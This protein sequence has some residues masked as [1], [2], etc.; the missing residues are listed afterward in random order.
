M[1]TLVGMLAALT[2]AYVSSEPCLLGRPFELTL[3]PVLVNTPQSDRWRELE[4][5]ASE[6]QLEAGVACCLCSPSCSPILLHA[7]PLSPLAR[8]QPN[9]EKWALWLR[10]AHRT[11][12]S[13]RSVRHPSLH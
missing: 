1:A 4:A 2:L 11:R 8:N 13:R 6:R 5:G 10:S 12:R 9:D 7:R 3:S